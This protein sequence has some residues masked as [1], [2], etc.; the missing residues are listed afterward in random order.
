MK[1][2]IIGL[3]GLLLVVGQTLTLSARVTWTPASITFANR[4]LAGDGVQDRVTSDAFGTY[5][6]G[7]GGVTCALNSATGDVRLD[8]TLSDNPLRT[9]HFDIS[10]LISGPGQTTPFSS[11]GWLVVGALLQMGIGDHKTT[12]AAF[13]GSLGRW[14]LWA[15]EGGFANG[16]TDVTATRLD[17]HTWTVT[18][19]DPFLQGAGD[20]ARHGVP[21]TKKTNAIALYHLPFQATVTC[22]TC[23]AP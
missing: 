12:N 21:L 10:Q 2:A 6:D 5:T 7:V 9:F 14:D 23:V 8:T 18:T 3:A 13:D 19:D 17:A 15:D 20:I 16:S 22:P 4:T 1:I 11:P